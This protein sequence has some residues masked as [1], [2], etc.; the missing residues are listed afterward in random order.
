MKIRNKLLFAFGLY[1]LVSLSLGFIA[2]QGL[3]TLTNTQRLFF[4]VLIAVA[5]LGAV[6]TIRLAARIANSIRNLDRAMKKI[7]TGDSETREDSAQKDEIA[8]LETSFR[9]MEARL[10][11]TVSSLE[12][13]VRNLHEKQ[14]QLV[15]S[16]ELASLGRIAAG[17]AHEI[18]N[19]LSIINEKA[20][21]IR[22]IIRSAGDIPHKDNI[23]ATTKSIIDNVKRCRAITHQLLGFARHMVVTLE[24]FDLNALIEE[25]TG[26]LDREITEKR[27][28]IER[29]LR[30]GLPS[31]TSDKGQLQQVFLNIIKNA[32]DAVPEEGIVRISTGTKN[33]TGLAVSIQDNGYGIHQKVLDHIFEPF[34]TTKTKGKG[35]GL[36]LF[37]SYGI[38][39]QLGGNLT[40]ESEI[41]RGTTF[42][43]DLPFRVRLVGRKGEDAETES[44]HY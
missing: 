44:A 5:L 34:F 25:V 18:N 39:K 23:E 37:I 33:N 28:R 6:L 16:E 29:N 21:L 3:D 31:I 43:I 13:A 24:E 17:V 26:F 14:E 22:D 7:A 36:G 8:S 35:T 12:L 11:N 4:Y 15:A 38:V 20:G 19:P 41:G 2:Y 42:R 30:A 32:V 9:E 40:V 27:V 10:H 1:L